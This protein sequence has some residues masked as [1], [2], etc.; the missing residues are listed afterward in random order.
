MSRST[1]TREMSADGIALAGVPARRC[2]N[3]EMQWWHTND[4]AHPPSWQRMQIYPNPMLGSEKS[5]RMVNSAGEEFFNQQQD[6][7]LAFGP[8]TVQLKALVKQVRAGKARYEGGY[9]AG[10]DHCDPAE[11]DS[12]HD[13]WQDLSPARPD[14]P[15]ELV[16]TAV[17]AHYRQGGID[18]DT[19]TMRSSV[20]GLYVA[21][22][23]GGHSNGLIGLATY[24]GKVVADG[25]A[26]DL[27]R[28][29]PCDLPEQQIACEGRSAW[30][31]LRDG[32]GDGLVPVKIKERLRQ[33]MWDKAG[34]EKDAASLRSGTR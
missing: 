10:F 19:A 11:V 14:F 20:P 13:L 5:A 1:G 12:L 34:V 6:D 29:A 2:V 31:M 8:Y 4:I 22:G 24:D 23:V 9:Y 3:M 15:R 18:V 33:V 30:I 16:E 17:T 32:S 21:G 26:A 25:V 27:P 28:L 7:P